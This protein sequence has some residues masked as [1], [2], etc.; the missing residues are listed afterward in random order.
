MLLYHKH[1]A[2]MIKQVKKINFNHVP[3]E[4]NQMVDALATLASMFWVNS[5]DEV[6]PIRMRLNETL[7]HYAQIE[8]EVDKNPWYYDT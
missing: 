3:R 6:Q 1:I 8:D 4:E 7:V 5:S 2:E